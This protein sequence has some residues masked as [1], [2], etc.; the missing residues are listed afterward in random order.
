MEQNVTPGPD[1]RGSEVIAITGTESRHWELVQAVREMHRKGYDTQTACKKLGIARRTYYNALASRYVQEQR[2]QQIHAMQD[3]SVAIIEQN[4]ARILINMATIAR[5]E[6]SKEAVQAARFVREVMKDLEVDAQELVQD[7]K[8]SAMALFAAR[9][10]DTPGK[11]TFR[12]KRSRTKGN[13][14]ITEEIEVEIPPD[15]G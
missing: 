10:K 13:N 12:A 15:E 5:S 7:S 14:R 8:E 6:G 3:A 1:S 4:W 11:K 9:M 2:V